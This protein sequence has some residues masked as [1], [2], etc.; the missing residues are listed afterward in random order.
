MAVSL[1]SSVSAMVTIGPRV[2]YAMAKNGAFFASAARVHERYRTPSPPSSRRAS[3][4][5]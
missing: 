1:I 5:A 2:Y 3:A 4:P